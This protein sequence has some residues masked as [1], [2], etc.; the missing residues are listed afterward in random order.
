MCPK[1]KNSKKNWLQRIQ[2]NVDTLSDFLLFLQNKHFEELMAM[3]T[4]YVKY[5][6]PQ[7]EDYPTILSNNQEIQKQYPSLSLNMI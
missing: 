7:D 6:I 5:V 1:N 4:F 2:N 3:N